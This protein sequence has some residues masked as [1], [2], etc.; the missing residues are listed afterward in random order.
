MNTGMLPV[1]DIFSHC[2]IATTKAPHSPLR[3]LSPPA[4]GITYGPQTDRDGHISV[5]FLLCVLD[6]L[7][8]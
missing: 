8:L 3:W 2:C 5:V 4:K 7:V 6:R 1:Q